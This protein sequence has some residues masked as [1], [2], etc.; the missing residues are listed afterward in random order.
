MA[1]WGLAVICLAVS[2]LTV[3]GLDR[4]LAV[5]GPWLAGPGHGLPLAVVVPAVT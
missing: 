4:V 3:A 5:V 2:S 1:V